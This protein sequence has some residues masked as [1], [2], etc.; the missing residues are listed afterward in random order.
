MT[1][2]KREI[3]A[4]SFALCSS[5]LGV[6]LMRVF[7]YFLPIATD[8]YGGSLAS[9]A[10]FTLP[11]QLIF[12]FA[13]PFAVYKLYGK[14]TVKS[15]FAYSSCAKFEPY[16]LLAIPLG[17][18]VYF[19][20]VFVSSAWTGILRF[21]G[22]TVPSSSPDM[23]S[24]F[25]GGFFV[26]DVLLTA[27]LPAVCEEFCMRGGMLTAARKRSGKLACVIIFGIM[28]GL[29]HQNVRQV[30]YT[31]LFGMLA[32]YVTLETDSLY[33]AMLMHFTNNFLSEYFDYATEYGWFG[34]GIFG[35]IGA[36]PAW[37][38]VAVFLAAAL[39]AAAVV[40]FILYMRDRN[41]YIARKRRLG[42]MRLA[43]AN[44]EMP[45]NDK[46][47]SGASET[48]PTENASHE[49]LEGACAPRVREYALAISLGAVTVLTTVFTYVWGFLY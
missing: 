46:S 26:A 44:G 35:A 13:V 45:Q 42:D 39:V 34:G 24:S 48:E 6:I 20:T 7:V 32:T 17:V 16:F 47:A 12:F 38:T 9:S 2:E 4:A 3:R 30:F 21:T 37:A 23:P 28:F 43:A 14:R 8:T 19:V 40:T 11:T 27:L 49:K 15:T 10:A 1:N 36:F 33:P 31:T 41:E 22:Y 18:A 25:S 5:V 29:F